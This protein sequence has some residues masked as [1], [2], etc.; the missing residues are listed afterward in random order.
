M[1]NTIVLVLIFVLIAAVAGVAGYKLITKGSGD[2]NTLPGGDQR[3][4]MYLDKGRIRPSPLELTSQRTNLL[5]INN[6]TP[7]RHELVI[8]KLSVVNQKTVEQPPLRTIPLEPSETVNVR[9]RLTAGDYV[10]YC[11]IKKGEHEHRKDGE[12]LQFKVPADR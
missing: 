9:I 11:D 1:N 6:T 4:F 12:E 5:I 3:T 2:S 7:E 10:I 8:A